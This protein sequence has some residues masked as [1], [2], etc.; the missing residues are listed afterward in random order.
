MISVEIRKD[1]EAIY[2]FL[3]FCRKI[4]RHEEVND[5]FAD[6]LECLLSVCDDCEC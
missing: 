4:N 2:Y 6:Y 5:E 1:A 3:L